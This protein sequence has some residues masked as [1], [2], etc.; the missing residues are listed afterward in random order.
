MLLEIDDWRT[1]GDLQYRFNKCF[2]YLT[3]QIF[4]ANEDR[5]LSRPMAGGTLLELVRKVHHQGVLSIKSWF[6][7]S[8]VEHL[9]RENFGVVA[10]VV[11]AHEGL[12][13]SRKDCNQATLAELSLTV[14]GWQ[15]QFNA[16]LKPVEELVEI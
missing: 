5:S 11:P 2:P 14:A 8:E 13:F 10:K 16:K 12:E 15:S 1:V 9:I 4:D 3:L 6:T 7:K